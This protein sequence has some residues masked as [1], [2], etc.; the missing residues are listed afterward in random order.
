MNAY[1]PDHLIGYPGMVWYSKVTPTRGDQLQV[2]DLLDSLDHRGARPIHNI[3]NVAGG[4]RTVWF[5]DID[6]DSETIRDDVMYDV[7]DLASVCAPDGT[8]I[9]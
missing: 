4:Y 3:T 8:R 6:G 9:R 2:G 1:E 7:V 5:S